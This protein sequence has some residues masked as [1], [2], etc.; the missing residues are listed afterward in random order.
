MNLT[1]NPF[2]IGHKE[3]KIRFAPSLAPMEL[4]LI[5]LKAE[6][7]SISSYNLNRNQAYVCE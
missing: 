3:A 1:A 6:E 7:L 5:H 2:V 4:P